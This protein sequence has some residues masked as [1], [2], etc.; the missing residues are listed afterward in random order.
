MTLTRL[1]LLLTLGVCLSAQESQALEEGTPN[2]RPIRAKATKLPDDPT[3][4]EKALLDWYGGE[5]S[6]EF[7]RHLLETAALER[8]AHAKAIPGS[9]EPLS[10]VSGNTWKNIGPTDANYQTQGGSNRDSGRVV[11][12]AVHPTD[13][14]KL[15][16]GTSG[17]GVWR[18]SDGG[19]SWTPITEA[20]GTLSTGAVTLDPADSSTVYLGLGN[21]LT[22]EGYGGTGLVKSTDGGNTWS[23][24]T[25][26]DTSSS[27]RDVKVSPQSSSQILVATNLG[28]YRSTNGGTSFTKVSS[29]ATWTLAYTGGS[30]W[31]AATQ[32]GLVYSRDGGATWST[33][34]GVGTVSR[35]FV[36]S[37][38]SN[39]SRC[40]ALAEV[41]GGCELY[42][43]SD[44]GATYS[45]LGASSKKMTN[46]GNTSY[47]SGVVGSQGWYD[48][49]VLI[50]PTNPSLIIA[51]GSLNA[52]VSRDGG[53]TWANLSDWLGY[54][55]L[56]YVH[57]DFHSG[58]WGPD[59]ALYLG[60]D[61]GIFKST[62]AGKTFTSTLN[63]GIS[64]HLFY[65]LSSSPANPDVVIGGLQDCGTRLRVGATT[66]Y[67][68]VIGGDG[69]GCLVH[70]KNASLMLGSLYYTDI[71]KSTNG[72]SSW[73][74]GGSGISGSGPF[75]SKIVGSAADSTGN[76]AYTITNT[77]VYKTT[78]FASSWTAM[79]TSGLSGTLRNV[80]A[81]KSNGQVVG[82]VT[83]SGVYLTSNGGSS[84]T[85][86]AALPGSGGSLSNL[87]FDTTNANT[88]YVSSVA[89]DKT[90]SHLWKSTNFGQ[91]WT[92]I[93]GSGFPAGIPVNVIQNDP[94][95]SQV[96]FA[97]TH[98]GVYTSTN[99]GSSWTRF[100]SGLPLVNCT[101]FYISPDGTM[102][103]AAT[104][105]RGIWELTTIDIPQ[106]PTISQGPQSITVPEGQT[107]TFSVTA[108]GGAPLVY[109]WKRNGTAIA[110][111]T[112]TSY[113]T[114]PTV[115][116][117]SGT[118]FTV[119]VSNSAGSV[120]SSP[121]ILTVVPAPLSFLTQPA[122]QT[123]TLGGSAT[124][125]TSVTGGTKPYTYAWQKNG[126]A[127]P[128]SN[129][130]TY[131][132]TPTQADNGAKFKVVV[133]D[134]SSPIK[135]LTSTE[136]TLTVQNVTTEK[137]VNGGFEAGTGS[138]TGST[139]VI[140][141]WAG[142]TYNQPAYEGTKSAFFG[143]NGK[144]TTETLHQTVALPST[145]TTATLSFYLHIDTKETEAKVYDT[146]AVQIR[147]SSGVVQ[148]T[149]VTYSNTN[150]AAGYQLR[151]FDV[152]AYKGQ[153]IQV[154]FTMTEDASLATNFL[155]DKVSLMVR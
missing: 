30:G 54:N 22:R 9:G 19:A 146:L 116:A 24:P 21:W 45:A 96:L 139:G 59:G 41:S 106:T 117:D 114:P 4:R 8:K 34:S 76:T 14:K 88:V 150:S 1:A 101:D 113:T 104:F 28:I 27:I 33:S 86:G 152:S 112:S 42:T 124:F 36:T 93:D 67:N 144:T 120:I 31:T 53:T 66:V 83:S 143:G 153:T 55:S 103:R 108:T 80:A 81:A 13:G 118:Q 79:G 69:F 35:V 2:R 95:N 11:S 75:I 68:Q 7:R 3:A 73:G 135:T 56:P 140:G 141:A 29:T 137:I 132:F 133:T 65:N 49:M 10:Y 98:L 110:S 72:G 131:T 142:G 47:L 46:S 125:T 149:L 105:G 48:Q 60:T 134:S 82:A 107:A 51:G 102:M 119:T 44:G 40:W 71:Y 17:G 128:S 121:A 63:K 64:T 154:F 84:W 127:I 123:V 97:G 155:V 151:S 70:P 23:A 129:L 25:Y 38:Q 57:A 115:L 100:G 61:G 130:A 26:F 122:N 148:K 91:S 37:S 99:G 6:P 138:W 87:W 52:A 145:L 74:D 78:N 58:A 89:L 12:I 32:G 18:T 5:A 15:Y 50:H 39:P 92:A 20:L 111:A 136:A 77:T 126:I 85:A 109:Q 43:S 147:N 90:K 62:D 94:T 16:I